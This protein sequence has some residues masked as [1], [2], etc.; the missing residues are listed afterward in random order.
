MENKAKR[1]V[2]EDSSGSD[3]RATIWQIYDHIAANWYLGRKDWQV[4]GRSCNATLLLSI[5]TALVQGRQLIVGEP[6]MGKTTGAEYVC[7]LI[8]RLPLGVVW[9]AEVAGHPEQ[10]EEKI[11]GRPDLGQLNLGKEVVQWSFFTLLAPKI[12]DEINRLPETKQSLILDGVDRGKWC[13]LNDCVI[14][15]EFCL[16]ATANDQDQGTGTIVAPLLDRFDLVVESRHPGPNL[17]YRI[18]AGPANADGLHHRAIEDQVEQIL[19]TKTPYGQQIHLVESLCE[20]FGRFIA[21]SIGLPTLSK[22]QRRALR[23]AIAQLEMDQDANAFLRLVVAELSFCFCHGQKRSNQPCQNGCHFTGYLCHD[24]TNCISNRF[25]LSVQRYAKALAWL[26]GDHRVGLNHVKPILPHALAH[27]LQWTDQ[28]IGR[29]ES[30]R[31]ND[32]LSI[33]MAK[34]AVE[35]MH[36]RYM[37]QSGRIKDALALAWRISQGETHEPLEGDHP[38]YW[39]IRKDLG[40]DHDQPL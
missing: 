2:I 1:S 3:L 17:A 6:G 22:A 40:V 21:S 34:A 13:Y 4:N 7:A 9:R 11:I 35:Q 5:L 26:M 27:R 16:F 14:N 30:D 24:I 25:A 18:A 31:R 29:F 20:R 32:P 33:H 28:A 23:A 8:F 19:T 39:E 36:R 10:T 15:D 12:V 37:E 38:L